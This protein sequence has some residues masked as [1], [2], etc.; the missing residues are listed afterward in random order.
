[1]T[2]LFIV[3]EMS[4]LIPEIY[5]NFSKVVLSTNSLI[6]SKCFWDTVSEVRQ[7]NLKILFPTHLS[8]KNI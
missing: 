3:E 4:L 6:K 5:R 2:E 1:M 8:E 7:K